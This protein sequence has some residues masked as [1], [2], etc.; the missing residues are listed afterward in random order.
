MPWD[1]NCWPRIWHFVL[2]VPWFFICPMGVWIKSYLRLCLDLIS[3]E[4]PSPPI[5]LALATVASNSS[6]WVKSIEIP[7]WFLYIQ[8]LWCWAKDL[9]LLSVGFLVYKL[10]I[11]KATCLLSSPE[12]LQGWMGSV[13]QITVKDSIHTSVI[14]LLTI[15]VLT[16]G[17]WEGRQDIFLVSRTRE[18]RIPLTLT[19]ESAVLECMQRM[20]EFH[21]K[22][23]LN[24]FVTLPSWKEK[25]IHGI[26]WTSTVTDL[27]SWKTESVWPPDHLGRVLLS[28]LKSATEVSESVMWEPKMYPQGWAEK[29]PRINPVVLLKHFSQWLLFSY[30]GGSQP[31]EETHLFQRHS[32]RLM[33][34]SLGGDLEKRGPDRSSAARRQFASLKDEDGG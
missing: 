27:W 13:T 28:L 25:Q 18:Q 15:L 6:C 11:I 22:S 10:G 2:S 4:F 5:L 17:L 8:T 3:T 23:H 21:I 1:E 32:E 30:I 31:F 14:W 7:S 12:F 19:P 9:S 24:T 33:E 16:A 29:Q 20:I 34:T 26:P